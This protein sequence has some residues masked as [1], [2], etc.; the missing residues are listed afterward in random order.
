MGLIYLLIVEIIR[1]ITDSTFSGILGVGFAS[2]VGVICGG[3]GLME[4]NIGL[5][6]W[7][8]FTNDN[9][10]IK[11]QWISFGVD[12]AYTLGTFGIGYGVGAL[13]SLIPGIGVFIAPFVSAG[14]T[15]LVDWTNERWKWLDDVKQWFND[16]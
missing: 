16:L 5:S 1:S 9:L 12:T 8:N 6:A 4:L 13:V 15:W 11:Q 14:V 7:P 3:Y 10:T 2:I